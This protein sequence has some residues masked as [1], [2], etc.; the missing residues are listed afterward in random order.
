MRNDT[1]LVE[2]N[3]KLQVLGGL[4]GF[5][6]AIPGGI[7][8]VLGPAW[9]VAG[10]SLDDGRAAPWRRCACRRM[11]ATATGATEPVEES[12]LNSAPVM[13]AA[14]SMAVI[15]GIVG[16]VTLL[17]AFQLRGGAQMSSAEL[18]ARNVSRSLG[19]LML[20]LEVTPIDRPPKWFFGVVVPLSVLG[21]LVGASLAP[22]LRRCCPRS[23]SSP[24]RSRCAGWP[25]SRPSCSAAWRPTRSSPFVVAGGG[26]R[27][28]AGV[29]RHHPARRAGCQQRPIVRALRVDAS[30]W[31]GSSAR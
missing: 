21:G 3:S 1:E 14:T 6:A 29:R 20:R 2:A 24:V 31:R 26:E 22:R 4:S 12:E 27:W 9:V 15:R 11:T 23:A 18:L 8:F 13:L 7:L 5:L 28:Q 16:F 30:R 19:E 25:A 17:M 10:C